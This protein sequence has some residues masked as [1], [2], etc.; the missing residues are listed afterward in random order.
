LSDSD[1][2]NRRFISGN[3]PLDEDLIYSVS[4]LTQSVK[5]LLEEEFPSVWL[6]GEISNYR[7]PSSGH[8]Y[9][10]LKD[11]ESQIRCVFFKWLMGHV[12]F[13]IEDG[14]E[15]LVRGRLTVYE[16]RGEY[17]ITVDY[18]EPRGVGAL[19]LAFEQLKERLLKE[20]LFDTD[21]K[22]AI[23]QFPEKI[24]IVTSPTGAAVK[25][26]L[27]VITRRFPNV[28]I[29]IC[30]VRVQGDGAAEEIAAGIETLNDI[31][32]ID[33]M[34][35]TR[36]GGSI[37][38]LWAFNEEVVARAIYAS[39]IP[40]ISAVGHEIDFTIS[41]FAAD[42]RAPT[43]SAAAELVVPDR[44][45]LKREIA[46]ITNRMIGVV[47]ND[48]SNLRD[49]LEYLTNRCA[50]ASPTARLGEMRQR[51][52][53]M[54]EVI[55]RDIIRLCFHSREVLE[56]FRER[57]W[58]Q[59]GD[60]KI[61]LLR[62][63]LTDLQKRLLASII[64]RGRFAQNRLASIAGK[65]NALSPLASLERGYSICYSHEDGRVIKGVEGLALGDRLDIRL[66]GGKL[67]CD[68]IK[69]TDNKKGDT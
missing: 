43:P 55:V 62:G 22:K 6:T 56:G 4:E 19:Q 17:Q 65:L 54:E 67:L 12:R 36:G 33:V 66:W 14:L 11:S 26:I 63:T 9:F 49:R 28:N 20:G 40:V 29:L 5:F 18:M 13:D 59:Q 45:E 44:E 30:P 64:N 15:V 61:A 31:G 48:I 2:N 38:D 60:K 41:D 16:A 10:A 46:D 25:D 8:A 32:G 1:T 34:I 57:I 7:L 24:G 35:V 37:E 21:K 3:A 52:D 23:P 51:L 42:L 27:S 69:I 39:N 58:K 50:L 53:D 68:I 47:L